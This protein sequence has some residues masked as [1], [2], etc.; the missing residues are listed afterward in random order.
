MPLERIDNV[1]FG[2]EEG[3]ISGMIETDLGFHIFKVEEKKNSKLKTF[4][5]AKDEIERLIFNGKVQKKLQ[6]YI[7]ELRQSAYIS[8]K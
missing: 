1:I 5:E 3:E 7:K 4:Q 2:L 6:E 8:Y